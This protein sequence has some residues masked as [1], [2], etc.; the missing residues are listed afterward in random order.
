MK[1][2]DKI[3]DYIV[4]MACLIILLF[5]IYGLYDSYMV[6][7]QANDTSLLKYKP[8]IEQNDGQTSEI[9]DGMVAWLTID[10]T[11]IDYPIMQGETNT[12]Y[13]NKT[14]Y[15]E[16]SMSGSIF[17]DSRNNSDFTDSYSL[18]YGHHM[19]RTAMF[20]ELDRYIDEGFFNHHLTGTLTVHNKTHKI[21]IFAVLETE[22]TNSY[23][24]APTETDPQQTLEYVSANAIYKTNEQIDDGERLLALS[25]CKYPDTAD[26]TVVVAYFD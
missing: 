13:L 19:E 4:V 5:G 16:Y 8:T 18:I 26:R 23:V 3:E 25:T 9:L 11:S 7:K 17:L 6:Y 22:G 10:G 12:E 20:G 21:H 2:V 15:G 1:I 14:P 24:F